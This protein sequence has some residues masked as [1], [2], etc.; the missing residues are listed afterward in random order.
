MVIGSGVQG[1]TQH[2]QRLLELFRMTNLVARLGL[3]FGKRERLVANSAIPAG[4]HGCAAQPPDSDTLDAARK[5]VLFALHRGSRFCQLPLFFTIAVN[6]WRADP[7]AVWVWKAVESARLIGRSLGRQ[8]LAATLAARTQGPI[9]GLKIALAWA[10]LE[11]RGT[12]LW[13][14]VE[15]PCTLEATRYQL[16]SFVLQ[17]IRR[18]DLGKAGTRK[19]QQGLQQG[20][21]VDECR[22]ILKRLPTQGLQEA[23][24]AVATGD[25]VTR[26]QSRFWQGHDGTCHCAVASAEASWPPWSRSSG[27]SGEGGSSW[28]F[29]HSE[30]TSHRG[31]GSEQ[32]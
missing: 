1:K 27:H 15:G 14:Q 8:A 28:P 12:S 18:R 32:R 10:A 13:S 11:L 2:Q 26:S 29:G 21:D 9:G 24:R 16:R 20:A 25:V 7:G 6:S 19:E 31:S 23:A 3:P 17:A 5:H 30:P 4:L 22:R